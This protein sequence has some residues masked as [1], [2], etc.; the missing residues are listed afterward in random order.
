LAQP[1]NQIKKIAI[2]ELKNE[3]FNHHMAWRD[4]TLIS[5]Q[6][7]GAPRLDPLLL[8]YE[9]KGDWWGILAD[10]GVTLLVTREYEHLVMAIALKDRKPIVSYWQVPHPSGLVV[11]RAQRVVHIASTRNPNLIYDFKPAT[12]LT[13]RL[14]VVLEPLQDCP[15]I[16]VRSRFFPGCTYIHDLALIDGRLYANAV[17]HNAVVRI[18]EDGNHRPVWWPKCIETEQG[19]VFGRNHIQLNSIAA[20]TNV[21][22]SYFTASAAKLSFRRP[23]HK[24]FAVKNRGVV[25]SG[26]TREPIAMGLTR[27]HSARLHKGQI[28]LGNSGYGE[29]GVI[30]G[31]A[32]LPAAKLPGWTRGL[33][34]RHHMAFVGTSRVLPRFTQYAPGLEIDASLCGVHAIDI[35]SGKVLGCLLWPHGDQIFGIDW[36]DNRVASGFPCVLGTKNTSSRTTNL[37]YAFSL[38]ERS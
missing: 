37:F 25:F 31:D 21:K 32:F 20:G 11:D 22:T 33:C 1:K 16:P 15:L 10:L 18:H 24:N 30:D 13:P 9:V 29:F 17:G 28:W 6:S 4:P 26:E 3:G 35:R 27:P 19:P 12:G 5:H 8:R 23:G 38:K 36:V 14:D 7:Q 34:F 2:E